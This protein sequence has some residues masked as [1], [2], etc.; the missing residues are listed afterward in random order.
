MFKDYSNTFLDKFFQVDA[1]ENSLPYFIEECFID[2]ENSNFSSKKEDINFFNEKNKP[3]NFLYPII[4][5]E[6]FSSILEEKEHVL[7]SLNDFNPFNLG[8][9]IENKI[10]RKP[11]FKVLYPKKDSLLTKTDNISILIKQENEKTFLVKK[12]LSN[13]KTRKDNWDNIPG[14]IKGRFFNIFLIKHLN[15]ILKSIGSNKY[16]EKF[17]QNFI[18]DI[19]QKR[20]K[21]IFAMTLGKVFMKEDLYIN[22]KK[23]WI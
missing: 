8:N 18:K 11:Y 17:P 10:K 15:E 9:F 1:I 5:Y 14:K 16:L 23:N 12:K 21:K 6:S 22:E 4:S 3:N 13:E 19:H 2:Y 20:N 7:E